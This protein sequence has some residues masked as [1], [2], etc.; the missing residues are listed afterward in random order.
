MLLAPVALFF[1]VVYLAVLAMQVYALVDAAITPTATFAAAGKLSKNAWL[2]ILAV[3]LVIT[4]FVSVLSLF[5]L[6]GIVATIV[7]FVDVRP[8]LRRLRS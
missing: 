6:A 7:Y 8:A 5:G 2:A 3:S 4:Q 1:R